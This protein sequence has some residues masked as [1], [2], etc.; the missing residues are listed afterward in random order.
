MKIPLR[1]IN[2]IQKGNRLNKSRVNLHECSHSYFGDSLVIKHFEHAWLKESFAKFFE[3]CY[4]TDVH[5]KDEGDFQR[6]LQKNNY[7][8]EADNSY[9]RPIVTREYDSSWQLFDSH[10]YPVII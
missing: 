2:G 6:I 1:R 4:F 10:L 8:H 7:F 5:G 9:V 3:F